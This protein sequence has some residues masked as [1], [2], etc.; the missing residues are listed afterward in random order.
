M[1]DM[2]GKELYSKVIITSDSHEDVYAI[3]PS[4]KLKPGVYLVTATSNNETYKKR[5]IVN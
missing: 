1:Y 3:E 4:Q 2:L 5:L